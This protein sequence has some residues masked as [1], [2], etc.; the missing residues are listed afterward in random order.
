M[1][2]LYIVELY[3]SIPV[4]TY[5]DQSH[6][7]SIISSLITSSP[8]PYMYTNSP[9]GFLFSLEYVDVGLRSC[10]DMSNTL[11]GKLRL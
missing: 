3:A 4:S 9:T 10:S 8:R 11:M 2:V 7:A 1:Y 5:V 6:T